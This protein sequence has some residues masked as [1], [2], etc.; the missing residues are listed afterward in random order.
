MIWESVYWENN[1][2]E[3][4]Q[5]WVISIWTCIKHSNTK[6]KLCKLANGRGMR[7]GH[8]WLPGHP[9]LVLDM[10]QKDLEMDASVE[11]RLFI[12]EAVCH[13]TLVPGHHLE[14]Q[15][16]S[17]QLHLCFKNL[18]DY[19][20][21]WT[22]LHIWK[23]QWLVYTVCTNVTSYLLEWLVYCVLSPSS[24]T[25]PWQLYLWLKLGPNPT[26]KI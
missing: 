26:D 25:D 14:F 3:E 18:S 4:G 8:L 2:H 10:L 16:R 11:Q 13:W 1:E 5:R 17:R 7:V 24:L 6:R 15:G 23:V 22:P 21:I 20:S 19:C 9:K 12:W